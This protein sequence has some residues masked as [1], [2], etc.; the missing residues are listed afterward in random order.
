MKTVKSNVPTSLCQREEDRFQDSLRRILEKVLA[1]KQSI[2]GK[3]TASQFAE[4]SLR[5][6]AADLT[7]GMKLRPFKTGRNPVFSKL[8]SRADPKLLKMRALAPVGMERRRPHADFC[9]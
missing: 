2:L 1:R 5:C 7:G 4:N 6:P 9:T 3:G 8:F